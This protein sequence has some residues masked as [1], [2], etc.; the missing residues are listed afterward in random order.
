MGIFVIVL[1]F[2]MAFAF[3][4][5]VL[6]HEKGDEAGKWNSICVGAI[7]FGVYLGVMF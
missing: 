5:A 4:T 6:L 7:A 3:A 1:Y 2:I